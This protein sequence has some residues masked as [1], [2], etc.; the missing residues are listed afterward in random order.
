MFS[1]FRS[2]QHFPAGQG[3]GFRTLSYLFQHAGK[4]RKVMERLGG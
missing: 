1:G 2:F 3:N 4:A